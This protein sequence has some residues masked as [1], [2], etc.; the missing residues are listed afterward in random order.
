MGEGSQLLRI[1]SEV[2]YI[3]KGFHSNAVIQYSYIVHKTSQELQMLSTVTLDCQ[4][5]KIVMNSGSQ[6]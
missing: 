3:L 6:F 4:L 1:N 5:T 2:Q